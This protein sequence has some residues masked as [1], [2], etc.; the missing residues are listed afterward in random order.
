MSDPI[1]IDLYAADVC[2][3]CGQ[4]GWMYMNAT[5]MHGLHVIFHPVLS[6]EDEPPGGFH[7]ESL[8]L[9]GYHG[10]YGRTLREIGLDDD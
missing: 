3:A 4:A 9:Y 7:G 5:R 10:Q 6:P 2:A 1:T 8:P